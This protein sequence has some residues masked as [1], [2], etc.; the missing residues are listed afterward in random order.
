MKEGVK[1]GRPAT[2]CTIIMFINVACGLSG[3]PW[4]ISHVLLQSCSCLLDTNGAQPVHCLCSIFNTAWDANVAVVYLMLCTNISRLLC[5][6]AFIPT[7]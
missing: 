6:G 7:R 3:M 5:S 2:L 1:N 4:P